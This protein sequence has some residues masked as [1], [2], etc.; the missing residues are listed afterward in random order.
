MCACHSLYQPFILLVLRLYC[1]F[2]SA[3]VRTGKASKAFG[4]VVC[5]RHHADSAQQAAGCNSTASAASARY[6][7]P[8]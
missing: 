7:K 1:V 4:G 2:T 3:Q 5:A 8:W 6:V